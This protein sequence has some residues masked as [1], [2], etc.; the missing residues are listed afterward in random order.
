[1]GYVFE[2]LVGASMS[3]PTRKLEII[4]RLKLMVT[5]LF[6]YDDLAFTVRV[7]APPSPPFL[8]ISTQP[9]VYC[10]SYAVPPMGAC[11][12]NRKK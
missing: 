10:S 8:S 3:R 2:D 12:P 5:L 9:R 7:R 1:M 6:T 4:S 11:H